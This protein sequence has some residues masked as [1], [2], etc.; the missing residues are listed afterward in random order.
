MEKILVSS[1][2][3]GDKTRY[4][5]GSNPCP[6][7]DQ[8]AKKY[9]LVPFCPEMEAGLGVPRE[10]AEIS[11]NEVVTKSG[12][13][14]TKEYNAAAETALRICRFLGIR[15]AIL[16]DGSPACGARHIHDGKFDD[17]KID[18]L[19]VTA[20]F[21]IA[22]GIKVYAETDELSFLLEEKASEPKL[23]LPPKKYMAHRPV[24][25]GDE[26]SSH[27]SFRPRRPYGERRSFGE[28]RDYKRGENG[29]FDN[30][31]HR[32]YGH[33][34]Y[35]EHK[36]YGHSSYGE[37]K[38]YG[39]SSYGDHKNYGHS[40]YGDKKP[41]GEHKDYGHSSY[42]DHKSYGHSSY[43]DKKPYGEHKDYGHS[44]YG[45]H[46]NYGHSSYGDKKTYG[47]HKDYGHSSYGDKKPYGEHKSYGHSSYGD[48]KP[49]GEHKDYGH[50]SYGDKK[51]YGEHKSYG[52]SSYGEHKNYGHSS[53]GKKPY[54][55]RK[56]YK[57]PYSHNDAKP[58]SRPAKKD[59][60]TP[61]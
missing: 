54:G 23:E 9:D 45:D 57:K 55:D 27:R 50:S 6:M 8:L 36:N 20:R 42:G 19:G 34:S 53:Y 15:I 24:E 29:S 32:S 28:H 11:H 7:M 60:T 47:E 58:A 49:Y 2:L 33:S 4:D 61:K 26:R 5:G 25:D 35:G 52:H 12:K 41:Y 51:S 44:S 13:N 21:L 59:D 17:V 1:C 30:D 46:K 14:L 39:H 16:K 18:G 48:K 10:P 3:L 56:G 37:H 43:G 38:D 31:E 40:S 22:N